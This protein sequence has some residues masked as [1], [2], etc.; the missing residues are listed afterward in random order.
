MVESVTEKRG[1][2]R[3][4]LFELAPLLNDGC[5]IASN[6]SAIPMDKLA[7]ASGRADRFVGMHFLNPIETMQLVEVARGSQTSPETLGKA[8]EFV[9]H[10]GKIPLVVNGNPGFLVNRVLM[11]YLNEAV[12]MFGEGVGIQTIDQALLGFGMAMGPFKYWTDRD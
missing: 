5:V 7:D 3:A 4:V 12:V 6:T 8:L 9:R 1:I 10:L 2:K 11:P